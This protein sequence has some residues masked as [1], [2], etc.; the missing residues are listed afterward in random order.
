MH[1]TS[2]GNFKLRPEFPRLKQTLFIQLYI[3]LFLLFLF[4]PYKMD[5]PSVM[6]RLKTQLSIEL[7]LLY[8]VE[9]WTLC[10]L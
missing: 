7:Y 5:P 8:R 3:F 4:V 2:N 10:K 1:T 6:K 9:S